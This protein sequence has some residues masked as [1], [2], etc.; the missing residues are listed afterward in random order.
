MQTLKL[1][2]E[3]C[4]R[5]IITKSRKRLFW[6]FPKKQDN[7]I[8]LIPRIAVVSFVDFRFGQSLHVQLDKIDFLRNIL[9][10]M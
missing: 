1:H 9:N 6:V 5:I 8:Q 3:V 7:L 10:C 2:A 4:T